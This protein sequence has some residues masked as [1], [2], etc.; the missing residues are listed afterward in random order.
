[1]SQRPSL[2]AT[3]WLP[4]SSTHSIASA[5]SLTCAQT[6]RS[7]ES[8]RATTRLS[9][10]LSARGVALR[11]AG[12]PTANTVA[13][14]PT[15]DSSPLSLTSSSLAASTTRGGRSR[16]SVIILFRAS[17]V[18]TAGSWMVTRFRAV[19]SWTRLASSGE[20]LRSSPPLTRISFSRSRRCTRS[21]APVSRNFMAGFPSTARAGLRMGSAGGFCVTSTGTAF[22]CANGWTGVSSAWPAS[23]EGAA[24]PAAGAGAGVA[25]RLPG[26]GPLGGVSLGGISAAD[27]GFA[28][29]A[30]GFRGGMY[31][32]SNTIR[33]LRCPPAS[34]RCN[35]KAS[36]DQSGA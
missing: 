32:P 4:G 6:V 33:D 34:C 5:E 8:G 11:W 14:F 30:W 1:M 12:A 7:D 31:T 10:S 9:S 3:I 16:S 2:M 18:S 23:S 27:A 22:A 20:M 29:G 21:I 24:T 26:E 13:S 15:S 36:A 28:G 35:C 17:S 19:P 25:G